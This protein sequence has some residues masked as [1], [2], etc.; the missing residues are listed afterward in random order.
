MDTSK[1]LVITGI[2]FGIA[3]FLWLLSMIL[4]SDDPQEVALRNSLQAQVNIIEIS[5]ITSG[6][7]SDINTQSLATNILS[8]TSSD[9]QVLS[10]HYRDNF[11]SPPAR[12]D[13]WAVDE[14]N[15]AGENLDQIYKEAVEEYLQYSL[16][17]LQRL[18]LDNLSDSF[19][20]DLRSSITNH[21][22]HLARF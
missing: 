12:A 7:S 4:G 19:A 13:S 15:Q 22:R 11:G 17:N 5:D 6:R 14:I 2:V 20:D 3:L 21:Q 1:L 18:D 8:T 9:Y 16:D 10:Q